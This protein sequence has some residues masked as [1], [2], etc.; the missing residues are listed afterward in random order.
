MNLVSKTHEQSHKIKRLFRVCFII[1]SGSVDKYSKKLLD[2]LET[3]NEIIINYE[4]TAQPNIYILV[5]LLNLKLIEQLFKYIK[6]SYFASE[7][8]FWECRS[9][10]LMINLELFGQQY[11]LS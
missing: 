1:Y 3:L 9:K 10:P 7:S 2:I 11:W 5:N 8:S 4:E 6:R